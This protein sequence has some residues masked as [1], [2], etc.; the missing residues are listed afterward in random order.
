VPHLAR[1]EDAALWVHQR[2]AAAFKREAFGKLL[3]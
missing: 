1:L 2:D 3:R